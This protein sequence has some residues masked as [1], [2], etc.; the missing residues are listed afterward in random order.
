MM[1]LSEITIKSFSL[2]QSLSTLVLRKSLMTS[3]LPVNNFQ[4]GATFL[5]TRCDRASNRVRRVFPSE[6]EIFS[7]QIRYILPTRS[8]VFPTECDSG[9][10]AVR[11][12]SCE[13]AIKRHPSMADRIP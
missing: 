12:V 8:D 13:V 2:K 9:P 10:P 4:L 1:L 5:P 7:N 3:Y 6:C 11:R